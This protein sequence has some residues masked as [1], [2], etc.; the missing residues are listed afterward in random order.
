MDA[1]A[2]TYALLPAAVPVLLG[3]TRAHIRASSPESV[4][5]CE[6][7]KGYQGESPEKRPSQVLSLTRQQSHRENSFQVSEAGHAVL[8]LSH[9]FYLFDWLI[10]LFM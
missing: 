9:Y 6:I 4:H 7:S 10:L 2:G 5:V 3:A 1:L 8:L